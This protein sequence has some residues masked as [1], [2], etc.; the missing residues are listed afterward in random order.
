M[1][2]RRQYVMETASGQVLSGE[3]AQAHGLPL[4]YGAQPCEHISFI[5]CHDNLTMF[6]AVRPLFC[7]FEARFALGARQGSRR[8]GR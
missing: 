1:R 4:A 7:R 6:D 3:T 8:R 2:A 5:G